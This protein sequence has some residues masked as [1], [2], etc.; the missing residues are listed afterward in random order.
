MS[1]LEQL[2][3]VRGGHKAAITSCIKEV[4]KKIQDKDYNRLPALSQTIQIQLSKISE[5]ND[6]ISTLIQP[7][8][9]LNQEVIGELAYETDVNEVL[10]KMQN[11][12]K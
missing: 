5:Q 12:L 10:V 4:D 2:V 7:E 11:A 9:K 6:V 1:N 3:R 8:E